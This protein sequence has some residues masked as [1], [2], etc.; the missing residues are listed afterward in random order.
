MK[1]IN[2]KCNNILIEQIKT[3]NDP[4]N[5]WALIP[6]VWADGKGQT[7]VLPTFD[8]QKLRLQT[9]YDAL[10]QPPR[11]EGQQSTI[12]LR[13]AIDRNGNPIET[14]QPETPFDDPHVGKQY[15]TAEEIL[16]KIRDSRQKSILTQSDMRTAAM[17]LQ[18]IGY[19]IE[20]ITFENFDELFVGLKDVFADVYQFV[21][22]FREEQEAK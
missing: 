8:W 5:Y 11:K 3:S 21:K 4:D 14:Q 9:W 13:A 18:N 12:V 16:D 15:F 1:N 10:I 6:C 2:L 17:L 20:K 22:A 7:Y 19:S